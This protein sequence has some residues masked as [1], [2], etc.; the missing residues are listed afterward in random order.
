MKFQMIK[1]LEKFEKFECILPSSKSVTQ[2][3]LI[4]A[5]LSEEVSEIINPLKSEDTILL[6]DALSL[7][8]VEIKEVDKNIWKV[9]GS[10]TPYLPGKKAY[11]GNN[12]TGS[13]FFLS[14]SCLG[15]GDY[16][17]IYGK[18][19]LHE[20]PVGPLIEVLRK[21]SA[22]ITCLEKEGHFPVR[23]KESKLKSELIILPGN[24]SSQ[25]ISALLLI[26]PCLPFGLEILVE[27]PFFSRPY[28]ELTIQVMQDFGVEVYLENN[29]FKV[30]NGNYR[31]RHYEIEAD[32]SNASYFLSIPLILG[33]GEV[34]IL[35]YNPFSKQ[36]DVKFLHYL[37]QMGAKVEK[38]DKMGKM[39]I[40]VSF[41]G[42][43]KGIEIDLGDTPDLFPTLCVLGAVAEGKTILKGAP[44]LRYKE[45]DRIK[46]MLTELS[47]VGV[48][49]EELPDG[50]I[51]EGTEK[52]NP[53]EIETYDDHRIAMAFSILG[54]KT[55]IF[56]IKNPECVNKSFPEFW[57]YL[58]KLYVQNL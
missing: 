52:F 55:G 51:V 8:G 6:R 25:F 12:G 10:R 38:L 13:R 26:G 46:A 35:N 36:G 3:A 34:V 32:A 7:T 48:R 41:E 57:N 28:V 43:P 15:K 31:G 30:K 20:R 45:T 9:R 39:G 19:R 27:E 56:K 37:L 16:I 49:V 23:V 1:K 50:A 40:K 47:K 33:K 4:C 42:R 24:I 11:L 5:A 2:R 17:E 58:E 53:A 14:F 29:Y 22:S 54:L 18:P 44:H 21:L